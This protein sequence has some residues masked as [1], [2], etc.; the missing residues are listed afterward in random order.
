MICMFTNNVGNAHL[1]F[2]IPDNNSLSVVEFK[3][4]RDETKNKDFVDA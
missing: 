3:L 2:L 4:K 1:D